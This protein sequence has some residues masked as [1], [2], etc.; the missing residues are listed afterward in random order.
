MPTF[1][2]KAI[3]PKGQKVVTGVIDDANKNTAIKKLRR[4]GFKPISVT[5]KV[6]NPFQGK[7]Q[8]KP[9]NKPVMDKNLIKSAKIRQKGAANDDTLTA[10]L[11]KMMLL[12]EKITSR[13]IRIFTQNFY[14]LKKA[15]FNNIHAL[16]T[17]VTTTE[18]PKLRSIIED[19]L[20]GVEAGEYM[21]TTM[22]YYSNVFPF[23]YINMIKVG[24]LSGSLETSLQQAVKYLDESDALTKKLKKILLPNIAMFIGIWVMLIVAVILGIPMVQKVFDEVGAD[25]QLPGITMWFAGVVDKLMLYWYIPLFI[26]IALAAAFIVFINTT[27]GRYQF[28]Y[29][30]YT[31]PIFGQLIYLI[32]F[33]RL[34]K[35]MLLNLQ[36]GMRI[37]DALEISKNVVKNV[38][39]LSMIETAINNIFIGQSWID[40]FD[41][42]KFT[43]KMTIEM[44][45]IGMQ[46]DLTEMMEKL[47]VYMDTDI[48]NTMEKVMK[49]LPEFT[50]LFVGGVLIFFVVVVVVP[51][52]QVYMGNFLFDAYL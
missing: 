51:M 47:L 7:E 27:R 21:Y 40:P 13:D 8:K 36:N 28:D 20:S 43:N 31:M 3:S 5:Q 23:I 49:V 48:D 52:V 25:T 10:K 17:V 12:T 32:D 41:N 38:V 44:L 11:D 22:E 18:N 33:S 34:T 26:V 24:E 39:M 15:D 35:N 4:N 42:N 45:R 1:S 30:K 19:I 46:T 9:M 2:Y 6:R 16:Q 50:Y 37:Q 29:F 14:L